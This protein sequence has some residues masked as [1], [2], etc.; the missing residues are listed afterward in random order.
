MIREVLKRWK[1]I[2]KSKWVLG[3]WEGTMLGWEVGGSMLNRTKVE[4]CSI[5]SRSAIHT[6]TQTHWFNSSNS[7]NRLYSNKILSNSSSW[8]NCNHNHN[9]P[10]IAI[11]EISNNSKSFLHIITKAEEV[12]FNL[13]LQVALIILAA[14]K[15]YRP[16]LTCSPWI[17]NS[18]RYNCSNNSISDRVATIIMEY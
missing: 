14:P 11:M 13:T 7:I 12:N 8:R 2:I 6:T 9:S 5:K 1:V 18:V 4:E 10:R 16:L 3:R 15:C 17:I